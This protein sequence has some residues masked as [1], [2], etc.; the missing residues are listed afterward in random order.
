M[1]RNSS[2]AGSG[3]HGQ[4]EDAGLEVRLL[5]RPEHLPALRRAAETV[6]QVQRRRKLAGFGRGD[7]RKQPTRANRRRRTEF[8][9]E[10][11]KREFHWRET[12]VR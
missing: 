11:K 3:R 2:A 7:D 4:D 6:A 1:C 12:F 5:L 9:S 10:T 8:D